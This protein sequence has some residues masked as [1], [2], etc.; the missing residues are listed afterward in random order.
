[1]KLKK[2]K[3]KT[4]KILLTGGKTMKR[5]LL[6]VL[7]LA[8]IISYSIPSH[9][10]LLFSDDF[11]SGLSAWTGSSGKIVADPLN[12]G[13]SVLSFGGLISGGD[14]FTLSSFASS[15]GNYELSFD[16]LGL[17]TQGSVPDDLGGFIGISYSPV[18]TFGGPLWLAG[19][20][21]TYYPPTLIKQLVDDGQWH[22]ITIS[23]GAPGGSHLMVEDFLGSGGVPGDVYFDNIRLDN[24]QNATATPEPA[25][26]LLL[27]S[28]LAGLVG[29]R[30]KFR[31]S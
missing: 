9:A 13:N 6:P 1:M 5:I 2:S 27:G 16:Y 23:F 4:T 12:P 20:M 19:T 29:F 11:E 18:P 30:R 21:D 24:S 31:K 7:A 3:K 15:T 14:T 25:T 28:G 22:N 26:M 17:A 10:G 8:F